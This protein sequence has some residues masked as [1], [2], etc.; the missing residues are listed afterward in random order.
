MNLNEQREFM[1]NNN[2][3]MT[4]KLDK[5]IE[6]AKPKPKIEK[7]PIIP[8]R[9][10]IDQDITGTPEY[11]AT[12][13]ISDL[14]LSQTLNDTITN[15]MN[16]ISGKKSENENK[17]SKE[18]EDDFRAMNP[19]EVGGEK[20]LYY[21]VPIPTLPKY[22]DVPP[23][24]RFKT[25]A[26]FTAERQRLLTALNTDIRNRTLKQEEIKLVEDDL[27][28]K[29]Y[30]TPAGFTTS[31][32][33]YDPNAREAYLRS[34]II[35]YTDSRGIEIDDPK[36]FREIRDQIKKSD[37]AGFTTKATGI[38]GIIKAIIKYESEEY[39]RAVKA[40][41]SAFVGERVVKTEAALQ[42]ELAKLKLELRNIEFQITAIETDIT[43]LTAD[44]DAYLREV[45][46]KEIEKNQIEN[47]S[48]LLATDALNTFNRLNQ[49]RVQIQREPQETDDA[50]M[51][52]IEN[53]GTL[54]ADPADVVN[55]ILDKA[56]KNILQLTPD[57]TKA[58]L[59][60]KNLTSDEQHMMNKIFPKIKKNY[61]ETFGTNNKDLN[62]N[63][64]SE[65]IKDQISSHPF[66]STTP[67]PTTT[68]T[69]SRSTTRSRRNKG[70]SS[71]RRR[72]HRT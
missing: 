27:N 42:T 66:K 48:R 62:E 9:I 49:G 12:R 44:Y 70:R 59:V 10:I 63:D 26:E 28:D 69:T 23:T 20:R 41:E 60:L 50:L 11:K 35:T 29:A 52:R 40:E 3:A 45:E 13:Q 21:D 43:A 1:R 18:V 8:N 5:I 68:T 57:L 51:K 16:L 24:T 36:P 22:N 67:A 4:L 15:A 6:D 31:I 46:Q 47:E 58:E 72:R 65:F 19:V 2:L 53:L 33:P 17:V 39:N 56:K 32:A 71:N 64:I 38:E 25:E 34:K 7:R 37:P 55:Q 14:L 30:A 54:K 61:I